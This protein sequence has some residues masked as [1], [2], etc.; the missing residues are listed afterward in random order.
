MFL[1]RRAR[2]CVRLTTLPPSVTRLFRKCGIL[3]ILQPYRPPLPL[4]GTASLLH[5]DDVRTSQETPMGLHGLLQDRFTSY[6]FI[7]GATLGDTQSYLRVHLAAR[8]IQ[9]IDLETTFV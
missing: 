4:T 7:L 2:Q 9:F 5:V 1:G 6:F 8:R 3:D